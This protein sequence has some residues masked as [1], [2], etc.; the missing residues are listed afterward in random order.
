MVGPNPR[1]GIV[2]IGRSQESTR[3][4]VIPSPHDIGYF[5]MHMHFT[6][7]SGGVYG[8][9]LMRDH[10]IVFDVENGRAEFAESDCDYDIATK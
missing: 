6:E 10:D 2:G 7:S 5:S 1:T 4:T 3:R 9:N 8:E